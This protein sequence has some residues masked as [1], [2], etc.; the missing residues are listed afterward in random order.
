MPVLQLLAG[1]QGIGARV[2]LAPTWNTDTLAATALA[3]YTYRPDGLTARP[4]GSPPVAQFVAG[5]H[6]SGVSDPSPP[7]P[8]IETEGGVSE[9][10]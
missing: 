8:K 4:K 6:G 9:A 7:M 3:V 2:P 1:L 10:T 5:L